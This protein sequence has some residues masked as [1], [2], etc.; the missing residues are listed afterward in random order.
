MRTK[1][2][3]LTLNEGIKDMA[4]EIMAATKHSS[5]T[6][7]VEQLIRDEYEKR[8]Q[9]LVIKPKEPTPVPPASKPAAPAFALNEP[10]N[11]TPGQ[12]GAVQIVTSYT[13]NRK[14]RKGT[15]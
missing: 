12:S 5:L 3:N 10:V 1:S 6:G 9:A 14:H 8:C 11:L 7:L 15:K 2:T 4:A 13:S